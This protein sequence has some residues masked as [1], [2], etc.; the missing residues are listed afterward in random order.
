MTCVVGIAQGGSIFLG[1]D[2]AGTAGWT[3]TPHVAHKVFRNGDF[4]MGFTSS[5][6]MG[7]LLRFAL[8]PPP[9]KPELDVYAFM[10]TDFV[11]AVLSCFKAGG[12]GTKEK[13][14]DQGGQF[15]VGY[16]GRLFKVDPDY[17]VSESI[18]FYDACGAG[19]AF[20][21][22]SLYSTRFTDPQ[23]RIS[24]ALEAAESGSAWVRRP[25]HQLVLPG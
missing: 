17:N 5:F 18:D 7:Q 3:T 11:G 24:I 20:A 19:E 2:S 14:Q 22:G 4:V 1:A 23:K 10:C 13:E 8:V 25:F 15:L 16:T 12:F 6:R 21:L 9:R